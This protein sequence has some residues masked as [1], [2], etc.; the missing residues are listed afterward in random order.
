MIPKPIDS[1][2]KIK[3]NTILKSAKRRA[4]KAFA[5][6]ILSRT[7]VLDDFESLKLIDREY[8]ALK[9]EIKKSDY[10]FYIHNSST[11]EW[12]LSQYASRT[13]L[14]DVD[15]SRE[16]E[17]AIYLGKYRSN[18]LKSIMKIVKRVPPYSYEKFMNGEV[19]RFFLFFGEYQNLAEGDYYRIIKWQTENII[20]IIS[21]ECAMLIKKI[22]N[23]CQI[24]ENPISFIESEN[25]LIDQL[26]A[27]KGSDGGEIKNMLSKMYIFDDFDLN[28]YKDY[29]LHENHRTYQNQEFHWHKADYHI[30]KPMADYLEL[31]PV[32]VFTSE[33]LIFQ[34]ID[35]IAVWFKEIL[36]G[37][38]IQKEY[39]LPD[40][41]KE[42]DRIENEAK[43]EIER[44]SDLMCDYINDETNSEKDI[45]SYMINLYDNNRSKL[46]AIKDKRVLELISNDKKHVLIDFFT[47]N[48]FFSNNPE[49]V[50]SN[51]KELIIVHELSW[52]ILVAYNDMFGTKNI[53]DIR[54]YGVSEI[55]MLLNKMVLNKKLYKTGKKAMD[56]FFLHFQKYSLPFDYHIKNIQEV[57]SEVFTTAMKNL[58][59]I[60]DDAQPTNKVIFLQSRIKEIKQRELQLRHLETEYN[61]E[62]TRN[63][64]SDLLKEFLTIEADF[65]KETIAISHTLPTRKEPLQLEMKATFE[66]MISKENQI[67][68][69]R[70]LEDLS[71]TQDGSAI[72]GERRKGAIR[73]IVEALKEKRILPDKS[74]ELLCKIIGDKIGLK[75]NSK[76][77]FTNT[78]ERYKKEAGQYIAENH[79]N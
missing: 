27:Y 43:E 69:S 25:L 51:L 49:K 38:D 40:Y 47:T 53:Y 18:L 71:I 4:D 7:K 41:P 61:Y 59:A 52:D 5:D 44:V 35:K 2:L 70:M 16:L 63:K 78:S 21:Y 19:C 64:Y 60:L 66:N 56:D 37:A 10:P 24:K 32:T 48:S 33:I 62:P 31:E 75:I 29:L 14:L 34:T 30:I 6:N 36:E 79:Q 45:K 55:T 50:E 67:F 77:D 46:N 1:S 39:V 28:N 26:L 58:Q 8:K 13:Y 72:I 3:V 15:E 11:P 22:Q 65:I 73:G 42:L 54:D 57:L 76:L 74:L 12:V 9:K 20:R 23:Y 17:K 68:I